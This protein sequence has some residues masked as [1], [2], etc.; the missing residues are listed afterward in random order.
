MAAA[1]GFPQFS[2]KLSK[3][4]GGLGTK[5]MKELREFDSLIKAIGECK[6][7][8]EE[9][10]IIMAETELLKQRLSDPKVD[11]SRGREYLVRLIYCEMLGH[12][13]SW[14]YIKAVQFAI[15][16]A[17]VVT[18]KLIGADLINAVFPMVVERLKHPKETVRK[19]A[20]MALHRFQQLDPRREGALAG[21]DTDKHLRTC[22]CDKVQGSTPPPPQQH[23]ITAP[24]QA[25][26]GR[27]Q[28]GK[29]Q[30]QSRAEWVCQRM[31]GQSSKL[32]RAAGDPGV[33]SAALCALHDAVKA[34][35][36]P[37]KNLI[38]SF[39]SILKQVS[40]HRLPK[41]YDYHRFPAPFIQIK[42]LRVLALL[43]AGDRAASE[44]IYAVLAATLRRANASHAIGNALIAECVRT[45]TAI[46]PNPH[47]LASAADATAAFIKSPS[48]NLRYVGVDALARIMRINP[49]AAQ[50]HQLAVVDCLEDPDDT[51]KLK[52]LEL[53]YR[54]T[55]GHNVEV[56]VE[57]MMQ[58]LR[59]GTPDQ[60]IRRAIVHK[61]S[62]LAE[63]YAPSP[64]W[65][66]KVLTEVFELGGDHVEPGL[67]HSLMRL[68]A[69]QD[70]ALH[71]SAVTTYL[72]L[73]DTPH[74]AQL[75]DVLLQVGGAGQWDRHG[76]SVWQAVGQAGRQRLRVEE[77]S[78]LWPGGGLALQLA[79]GAGGEGWGGA[80]CAG[81]QRE[82]MVWV[83]GEY[84]TLAAAGGRQGPTAQQIASRL[85]AL[86][87]GAAASVSTRQML[88][89]ALTKLCVQGGCRLAPDAQAW[90][91]SCTRS[92]DLEL[93]QRAYEQQALLVAL[94]AVQVST[95]RM[96]R[97]PLASP[98][99]R[100]AALLQAAALPP[101]ASCEEIEEAELAG[102]R[103]LTFLTW[104]VQEAAAS[105]AQPFVPKELRAGR[106]G[107]A[108]GEAGGHALRF[109]AYETAPA[110][111]A[112][113]R[114]ASLA[115]GSSSAGPPPLARTQG[116][117]SASSPLPDPLVQGNGAS[118]GQ[119]S[120]PGAA[121]PVLRGAVGGGR[122]GPAQYEARGPAASQP[123]NG[124]GGP[125]AAAGAGDLLGGWAPSHPPP[126]A[127]GP[128]AA[129]P[130]P[131]LTERDRLAA[132]LFGPASS[133]AGPGGRGGGP[134]AALSQRG[135][136]VGAPPQRQAQA[137]AAP[138]A[139]VD[140]LAWDSP[141]PALPSSSAPGG[142]QGAA[143]PLHLLMGFSSLEVRS[144]PGGQQQQGLAAPNPGQQAA[145][146]SR[147]AGDPWDLLLGGQLPAAP[148]APAGQTGSGHGTAQA[149]LRAAAA[150]RK[151]DT[152]FAD[153]I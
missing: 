131:V 139:P 101:D 69:E 53:L 123:A 92:A 129:P 56:I 152:L 26:G 96:Q 81:L 10:R 25:G 98:S 113:S 47:L 48:H 74:A 30:S 83:L 97:Q 145:G 15:S 40:E 35:P 39:T 118:T 88:L 105:G 90:V 72:R 151:E 54:M 20:I 141:Q 147:Q 108:P 7:K 93:Q 133:A 41:A 107:P 52:T 150:P 34:D 82:V 12:D 21:L 6:S 114:T 132:S 32:W 142:T 11:K 138:L 16:T 79:Q 125:H 84:G 51:L 23:H 1:S 28:G 76:S 144:A 134:G 117:A 27:G 149:G 66:I 94:P 148:A 143:D 86:V 5:F 3:L 91:D 104:Y 95:G 124:L 99:T 136:A 60:H 102:L 43:G 64:A 80:V 85:V 44:N 37:Y 17:L 42:L 57:R 14:A 75:P 62:D 59:E 100:V 2:S 8:S 31:A 13:T 50:E 24:Q 135:P 106:A 71:A 121:G 116:S 45:I 19:K 111:G 78:G 67:A 89:P 122:W 127:H 29:Q 46:Y 120:Q 112:H 65:F 22:L 73:L 61:V 110:P 70:A 4:A 146:S 153:L 140:L 119:G 130:T 87:Q 38:P 126:P 49:Q 128:A 63:R 36:R 58:Y 77:R 137:A 55:K 115:S 68:I 109:T 9:D 33:M 103:H 18:T